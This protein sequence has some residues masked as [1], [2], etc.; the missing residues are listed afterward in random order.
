MAKAIKQ[1]TKEIKDEKEMLETLIELSVNMGGAWVFSVK[2]FS[3]TVTFEMFQ[4]PSSVPDHFHDLTKNTMAHE[5][6]LRP[7][8]KAAKRRERNRGLG[9]R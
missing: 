8:T 4:N 3:Y 7:F 1:I 9:S 6:K 5:G 2:P